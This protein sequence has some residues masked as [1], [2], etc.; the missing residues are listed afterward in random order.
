[1]EQ[2][3]VLLPEN[4]GLIFPRG[5]YLPDGSSCVV[6]ATYEYTPWSTLDA[7]SHNLRSN[8][9]YLR[10][11]AIWTG[12]SR[13]TRIVSS[14]RLPV[15]GQLAPSVWIATAFGSMGTSAAPFA[16]CQLLSALFGWVPPVSNAL[17]QAL[18][19]ARFAARQARRGQ[20]TGWS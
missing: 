13:A 11:G 2:A 16:A 1:M 6:G 4:H 10:P 7:T 12:R 5:Y 9:N 14:D 20:L 15:V 18:A 17:E 19:P 3:C 8:Q